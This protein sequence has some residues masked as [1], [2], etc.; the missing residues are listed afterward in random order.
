VPKTGHDNFLF[1]AHK[2]PA[3]GRYATKSWWWVD[4]LHSAGLLGIFKG[5]D[6]PLKMG[7]IGCPETSVRNHHYSL[8]NDPEERRSRLLHG[9]SLKSRTDEALLN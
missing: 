9:G 4:N 7:P 8:R 6:W 1:A 3:I 2:H 5:Q